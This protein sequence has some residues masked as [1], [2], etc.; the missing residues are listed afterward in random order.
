MHNRNHNKD[1]TATCGGLAWWEEK[2]PQ[3][4]QEGS[5]RQADS[6]ASKA[7]KGVKGA[8]SRL[9]AAGNRLILVD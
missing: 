9:E 5:G 1:P 2:G 6:L 8:T 3:F 4:R 7:C